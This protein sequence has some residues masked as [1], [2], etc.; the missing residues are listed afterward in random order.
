[1]PG[2]QTNTEFYFHHIVRLGHW[3]LLARTEQAILLEAAQRR[4]ENRAHVFF[5]VRVCV[6]TADQSLQ[7]SDVDDGVQDRLASAAAVL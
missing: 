1:M 7:P 5:S 2:R 6:C 4:H 3:T